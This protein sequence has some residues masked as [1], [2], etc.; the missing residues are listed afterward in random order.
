[1]SRPFKVDGKVA[2]RRPQQPVLWHE[3]AIACGS[4]VGI[5]NKRNA[6]TLTALVRKRGSDE[7]FGISCNHV[8]GGCSTARP[9][10]PIVVPGILDVS[11]EHPAMHVIGHHHDVAP[12]ST[13]L[14]SVARAAVKQNRDLACFRIAD[15]A[16]VT[17]VQGTGPNG[18][19]TPQKTT[20]PEPGMR[21]KKWGRTTGFTHGTILHQHTEHQPGIP[22]Q[23]LS[24]YGPTD[25]QVF[26]GTVYFPE[27]FTIG[28]AGSFSLGGDSGALVVETETN[29]AVGIVVAGESQQTLMLP[30][31]PALRA[32]DLRLVSGHVPRS[33]AKVTQRMTRR[34]ARGSSA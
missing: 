27:V 13:G 12:M 16:L 9:G 4:S 10:V 11:A 8:T 28:G 34:P 24:H 31:I 5:G 3:G 19:D 23:I 29:R 18:Y 30:I 14:P 2:N 15:E 22:Y 32:L 26:Q 7:L 1:M 20:H 17:S 25:S 33:G 21:V 6:G